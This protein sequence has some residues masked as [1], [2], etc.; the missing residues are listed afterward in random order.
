MEQ[1]ELEVKQA[2]PDRLRREHPILFVHGAWH[3]AWAWEPHFMPFFQDQGYAC[4]ALSLRN[5]GAS[6]QS[7]PINHARVSDYVADIEKVVQNVIRR[8]PILIGHSLGGFLVQ[9]YL[10][11]HSAPAAVL[12]AS[13]PPTGA[14]WCAWRMFKS[15][16]LTFL[17]VFLHRNVYR[18]VDSSKKVRKFFLS[19]NSPDDLVA[20]V[21]SRVGNE[22]YRASLEVLWANIDTGFRRRVPIF[23]AGA[24][25]DALFSPDEVRATA[26]T[27]KAD[28]QLFPG[29]AHDVMLD[30]NWK[31]A[32]DGI[33]QWLEH[34]QR[35]ELPSLIR[36]SSG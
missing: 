28:V 34:N 27:Y 32:A 3:N 6:A 11:R 26:E 9:K 35:T 16:P 20:E 33:L 25:D 22:S 4:Y 10:E 17:G 31:L 29:L 7:L 36:G 1:A 21:A 13:V 12:L 5:H 18:L 30:S 19:Q 23:V 24:E 15:F 2:M 8:D 14:K